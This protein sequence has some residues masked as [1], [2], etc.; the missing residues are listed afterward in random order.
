M[1]LQKALEQF[2]LNKKQAKLYLVVLELG[3]ATVNVIAHK[4]GIARSSC[5][6]ILDS[7][8]KKGI[9]SSFKK[10]TIKCFSVDDPKRIFE[11]AKQKVVILEKSLPQ[12]N[13]LYAS[14]K[15]RPSIRFYQGIEGMKQI[16][17]EI[18]KDH[19]PELLSFGSADDLLKTMGN[20]HLEFVKKRVKAKIVS[21]VILRKTKKA[22]ERKEL[23]K[24]ELR[25]VKFVSKDF[26][27]QGN[28]IIFGNKL[29][30]FSFNK[31]HIAVI[32]ESKEIANIQKA[33]FEYI[34]Q[35]VE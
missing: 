20:Y 31:D 35:V 22:Q 33:M 28:A 1:Q 18:L 26:N 10:K 34:W 14:A 15:E 16:F 32:I 4:S 6:D 8:V 30:F 5:Y 11:L 7:L 2:G 13:A 9:A 19:N 21:R 3:S 25:Q 17:E 12:L 23:G 24:Y 29:A 27:C